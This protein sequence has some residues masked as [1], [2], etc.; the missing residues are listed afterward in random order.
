[1][2]K[3]NEIKTY[4]GLRRGVCS[5]DVLGGGGGG[6][7]YSSSPGGAGGLGGG[8]A[9]A[10]GTTYGGAG[11][12]NGANGNGGCNG[13]WANVP[14]SN[15]G[16]NTGGGGGG[17]SHYNA[18]NYGGS[19]GS[20]IVI[21]KYAGEP[22]A[23]GGTIT[24]SGGYTY[25]TFLSSGNFTWLTNS[26]TDSPV[27]NNGSSYSNDNNGSVVFNGTNQYATFGSNVNSTLTGTAWTI[28][29][30]LKPASTQNTYADI[31]GSHGGSCNC[32]I[33]LQQ[34]GSTVNQYTLGF[35][36]Q[37]SWTSTG[38]FSL[39]ADQWQ[40]LTVTKNATGAVV[41]VNNVEVARVNTTQNLT[42][43]SDLNFMIAQGFDIS[44]GRY[45]K[46]S[47][48]DFKIYNRTFT[49]NELSADYNATINKSVSNVLY[50]NVYV[51]GVLNGTT[52]SRNY[53]VNN[54]NG[55]T[56]YNVTVEPVTVYGT[57]S[58][59]T[60]TGAT[61]PNKPIIPSTLSISD[62]TPLTSVDYLVVAGGGA[63][64]GR[65]GGGG[66]AG[67]LLTGTK[68]LGAGSYG[69][70]IGNGG[71][72]VVNADAI[73][74]N[75]GN[76]T[77]LGMTAI[78]GGG[79]GSW[80]VSRNGS[81]GGSGGGGSYYGVTGSA[82]TVGQGNAGGNGNS[83]S[84]GC[85]QSGGG[86]GAGGI[87]LNAVDPVNNAN[88][89]SGAGG[90][91]IASDILGST[92]YFAGGGGGGVWGN[93]G[94][95]TNVKG[96]N[97]GIGGGGG[98]GVSSTTAGA[99]VGVGGGTA[100]NAGGNGIAS[101]TNANGGNG[102]ANTGSG[103][104]GA[105]ANPPN[106]NPS[107]AAYAATSGAGGSGIV[108]V[109]YAGTPKATGG[110]ITQVNGYTIH[111]FTSNGTFVLSPTVAS[112]TKPA[113]LDG[114]TLVQALA[115]N[116]YNLALDT[117]GIVYAWGDNTYGQTNVP[118]ELTDGTVKVAK[119]ATAVNGKNSM[120]I[121]TDG[122][123]YAWGDNTY[124]QNNVPSSFSGK[125][126]TDITV[127]TYANLAI[128]DG[129]VTQW[130]AGTANTST[131]PLTMV[132]K[133]IVKVSAGDEHFI[134][135]DS[136]GAYYFW[137]KNNY[138]G[139]TDAVPANISGKTI[140][141]IAA[142]AYH[143]VA[144]DSN[145]MVYVWGLNTQGQNTLPSDIAGKKVT[146]VYAGTSSTYAIAE[147]KLFAW[148]NGAS[149]QRAFIDNINLKNITSVSASSQL[150][151]LTNSIVATDTTV[152]LSWSKPSGG[153]VISAYKLY[154]NGTYVTTTP[155]ANLYAYTFRGLAQNTSYTVGVQATNTA[156]DG[157]ITAL[158]VQTDSAGETS[159]YAGLAD[160][161]KNGKWGL[162]T[163]FDTSYPGAP[164]YETFVNG[165]GTMLYV[166]DSTALMPQIDRANT[167]ALM[168][169][170]YAYASTDRNITWSYTSDDGTSVYVDGQQIYTGAA[171]TTISFNVKAGWH[172]IDLMY[173]DGG[174][175][176]GVWN[177]NRTVSGQFDGFYPPKVLPDLTRP[178]LWS[179]TTIAKPTYVG[180][181]SYEDI[182][183]TQS[184]Q[185]Y[186]AESSALDNIG[187]YYIGM[188]RAVVYVSSARN[189][190]LY[191]PHDDAARV[192][193]DGNSVYTYNG[194]CG[195]INQTQYL[196]AGWH[197]IDLMWEEG[198]G[199][200][201]FGLYT[202]LSSQV[203]SMYAPRIASNG[204]T[205]SYYTTPK[206]YV[207]GTVPSY[208]DLP[209]GK[210]KSTRVSDGA[211][212]V[213]NIGDN[214][215]GILRT[216]VYVPTMKTITSAMTLDKGAQI[217]V[218]GVSVFTSTTAGSKTPSITIPAGWHTLDI[219]WNEGTGSTDGVYSITAWLGSQVSQMV[220]P[221]TIDISNTSTGNTAGNVTG[222]DITSVTSNT[223]TLAWNANSGVKGYRLQWS[224]TPE[225]FNASNIDLGPSV[226]SA[227]VTGL[228]A[229]ETYYFRIAAV[230]SGIGN[231]ST[232]VAAI[233]NLETPSAPVI[234]TATSDEDSASI[235]WAPSTTTGGDAIARTNLVINPSFET[236]YAYWA[237]DTGIPTISTSTDVAKFGTKSLKLVTSTPQTNI[238]TGMSPVALGEGTY[239]YSY[240]VYSPV[241]TTAYFDAAD[242]TN[243]KVYASLGGK[244]TVPANTWTR[245]VGTFTLSGA[246]TVNIYLHN[247]YA[248]AGATTMY[249]DGVLLEA[250]AAATQY[251]DGSFTSTGGLFYTWNGTAGNSTSKLTTELT[252][253]NLA[254]NPAALTTT[255]FTTNNS[256][257]W[258][259]AFDTS[260]KRVRISN[261]SSATPI[262]GNSSS[263]GSW[264]AVGG[265]SWSN[266]GG[267]TVV[268]GKTY[269]ASAYFMADQYG[270]KGNFGVAFYDVAG[271]E[272]ANVSY[273]AEAVTATGGQPGVWTRTTKTITA[274][275]N[276]VNMR[277]GFG[278]S[279]VTGNAPQ[280]SK[281]WITDVQI[282]EGTKATPFF[283][284]WYGYDET[285]VRTNLYDNAAST[286]NVN[287]GTTINGFTGY[288]MNANSNIRAYAPLANLMGGAQYTTQWQVYNPL[289][290]EAT[291][292]ADWSDEFHTTYVIAPGETR[293]ITVTG[294]RQSYDA[295]YRF[296]DLNSIAGGVLVNNI[297][298]ELGDVP[299]PYFNGTITS[300]SD[301]TYGWVSGSTGISRAV[302]TRDNLV[303]DKGS[304]SGTYTDGIIAKNNA[305]T[306]LAQSSSIRYY[307]SLEVLLPNT[308]YTSQWE[309]YND[310][311]KP[312]SITVD[313]NDAN[314]TTYVIAPGETKII[315]LTA[316]RSSYDSTFRFVD[317][318]ADNGILVR[319]VN[320]KAGAT[321]Q[322]AVQD[323]DWDYAFT[324]TANASSSTAKGRVTYV[325]E[326]SI[327]NGVTW[328]PVDTVVSEYYN[329]YAALTT[330]NKY[331][332]RVKASAPSG[333]SAWTTINTTTWA[334]A[335]KNVETS[336]VTATSATVT[337]NAALGTQ[338]TGYK[339][340]YSTTPDF[341]SSTTINVASDV[342]TADIIGL[343]A[344]QN[345]YVRVATVNTTMTSQPSPVINFDTLVATP[346][347]PVVTGTTQTENAVTLNWTPST[348]NG[349][350]IGGN[351][352]TNPSFT[353]NTTGWSVDASG[354]IVYD[355]VNYY[356][357][358]GANKFVSTVAGQATYNTTAFNILPYET[359]TA[360]AWVK[361][362]AG[363]SFSMEIAEYTS[364][365]VYVGNTNI[366][367]TGTGDWQRIS[368]SRTMGATAGKVYFVVR[369][370]ALTGQTMYV[371]S[372]SFYKNFERT[373]LV[374]N[375]NF[376]ANT[377]GWTTNGSSLGTT[378]SQKHS[379]T[380]SAV[381]SFVYG[382]ALNRAVYSASN[383]TVAA[384]A[385]YTVSAWVKGDAG[386][387][388]QLVFR[389]NITGSTSDSWAQPVTATGEW[390]R[391]SLTF[392]TP[393]TT[394]SGI[395]IVQNTSTLA[396]IVY[397]DD[398]MLEQTAK[399][400]T[401]FDGNTVVA[402]R[403]FA[404]TGNAN[405]SSSTLNSAVVRTNLVTSP[406]GTTAFSN[407]NSTSWSTS[408]VAA[409]VPTH[410]LGITTAV[411]SNQ[412]PE[413]NT[414]KVLSL[415]NID[416]LGSSTLSRYVGVWVYVANDGYQVRNAGGFATQ[417]LTAG[418]WTFVTTPSAITGWSGVEIEKT[419]GSSPITTD[420][421]YA[422]GAIAEITPV[423]S[424]FDAQTPS[425]DTWTYTTNGAGQQIA[426]G[427]GG[428][429]YEVQYSTDGT[430]WTAAG[431]TVA[432]GI[433]IRN[434]T[435]SNNYDMRVRA[436]NTAGASA[437]ATASG[438]TLPAA[439]TGLTASEQSENSMKLSWN[440]S[441]VAVD[442]Y[443]V[444]LNDVYLATVPSSSTS[445]TYTALTYGTSY[446]LS[447]RATTPYGDGANASTTSMTTGV[448]KNGLITYLDATKTASYG[449]GTATTGNLVPNPSYEIDA[450]S[451]NLYTNATITRVADVNAAS[452]SYVGR[453]SMGTATVGLK[454]MPY[455]IYNVNSGDT[456]ST[457][458]KTRK[459]PSSQTGT[460]MNVSVAFYNSAGNYLSSNT[461]TVVTLTDAWQEVTFNG[462][463]APAGTTQAGIWFEPVNAGTTWLA[464][465]AFD[466]DSIQMTKTATA[467][468]YM[469]NTWKDLSGNANNATLYNGINLKTESVE[470]LVVAGGGGGGMDMGGGGGGGG[471]IYN[472]SYEVSVGKPITVTVGAGGNGGPAACSG[473]QPCSHQYT[474]SAT[475]GGNSSFGN[476]TAVGGGYGGSSYFGYTPNNGY[477]ATGGSGGGAS[478]YSDG[479]T[480][481]GGSG[482]SGQG[483][484][485]GG[486]S[487]QYYSGGGGGAAS[488]GISGPSQPN[489]GSGVRYSSVS[490]FYFGGGGGGAEYSAGN[491]GNGGIGG[492]G[493]GAVGVSYG[494]QGGINPGL[495]GGGGANNA[496]TNQPGGDAGANTGG[497]GGGGS[498]YNANN[499]GGQGGSGIVIVKY[500]G[501]P[502]ATGGT[503]TQT[504]GYTYHTFTSTGANT[505]AF[506]GNTTQGSTSSLA[507]DGINQ[508]GQL[509]AGY[510]NFTKGITIS[511]VVNLGDPTNYEKIVDLG[512]GASNN[513]ILVSRQGTTNNLYAEVW[514]G[515]TQLFAQVIPNVI[516]NNEDM[517]FAWTYD[518]TTST[519]NVNGKS[520]KQTSVGTI[521]NVT[522]NNAYLG[523]SNFGDAAFQDAM[524]NIEIYNRALTDAEVAQNFATF[525]KSFNFTTKASINNVPQSGLVMNLDAAN[526]DSYPGYGLV[527]KDLSGQNTN[528]E[529]KGGVGYNT[530]YGGL[531]TFDGAN[532][533]AQI[534]NTNNGLND[535][536]KGISIVGAVDFG[537]ADRYERFIDL[538]N[539]PDVNNI[540]M[541]REDVTNNL[542]VYVTGVGVIQQVDGAIKNNELTYYAWSYDGTTSTLRVNDKTYTKSFSGAIPTSTRSLSYIGKSQYAS[543]PAFE[544]SIGA[545]QIYNR[546]LTSAELTASYNTYNARY[547]FMNSSKSKVTNGLVLSYDASSTSSY[548]G[549][550]TALYDI[551]GY[552][553]SSNSLVQDGLITDLDAGNSNS[554]SGSG[555]IWYNMAPNTSATNNV[556][557][558]EVLTVAGGGAGGANLSGGGGGG[559]V[560]YNNSYDVVYGQPI[561]VTVGTGGTGVN[562]TQAGVRGGNGGN[563]VFGN[564]T[565][566]GGGGG[567]RAVQVGTGS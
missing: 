9:G 30:W 211:N 127:G 513:N 283:H 517:Y 503:I 455:P 252:R 373:N 151:V 263:I 113:S 303:A 205:W 393:A 1:M 305:W 405:A 365:L 355:A 140:V 4:G 343:T 105:A 89:I 454:A 265:T 201:G 82:G 254:I 247:I 128:V 166:A 75:G 450:S 558:V 313:W 469:D 296:A 529:L 378:T 191:G 61:L 260:V 168:L 367:F 433:Q 281:A 116:G 56:S 399:L 290:T 202:S 531:M 15:A 442:G 103:G 530:L 139:S 52:T 92:Y 317:L 212:L 302:S 119:I 480:G 196:A 495:P 444:Y 171:G 217:Y 287:A 462:L 195:P 258:T 86:G 423:T 131:P 275:A 321:A 553:Q 87:G 177:F 6:S 69:I 152:T 242:W 231:F 326:R 428:V 520:Y 181:P 299:T 70:T 310:K 459:A 377:T 473:S 155:D 266:A 101:Y 46:G 97:G 525:D 26:T 203:D 153:N 370:N 13:C 187:D 126:A 408:Y 235:V 361:A 319:N 96:G 142:G 417:P 148:G 125:K 539:G 336:N 49:A 118:A 523:K 537:K 14:G 307:M 548:P 563:S 438:K 527:W 3:V 28:S 324:G 156:G 136:N 190:T 51:N 114:K 132:G 325:V 368:A 21:V 342:L 122:A 418:T 54:L 402:G 25:H 352:L 490:P 472:N 506:T 59:S 100:L 340:Q 27:L 144:V 55:A 209:T 269:T 47:I 363:K 107:G 478:G 386:K 379:G 328:T 204:N 300:N 84:C 497:G 397:I 77:A 465:D 279:M 346:S 475:S 446:K 383:I 453:I 456:V 550:G 277:L 175:P 557:Q 206:T 11:L 348:N 441:T 403:T 410:P 512:N 535:F 364:A 158:N 245:V 60:G 85:G 374:T 375:P 218:D 292:T 443:K 174:G 486:S 170:G 99:T 173:A 356:A 237:P 362:E 244:T 391:L 178:N 556:E 106:T 432:E 41:Y 522:R 358:I 316:Q 339:V 491:G 243:T 400:N 19:G 95:W 225:M 133:T 219:M 81:T 146:A 29:T 91:G 80:D 58:Q 164:T 422:T 437:W 476:V 504:G 200:D 518:G 496:Q 331:T 157:A 10:V 359:Y 524:S 67:G 304:L 102:G 460:K 554:Y 7:A 484:A 566:I 515:G 440:A 261:S 291:V 234:K 424:Y 505:F 74:G 332:Y 215:V 354:T 371:D 565:A 145:G 123:V 272:L 546:A 199:G 16:A 457:T 430:N 482:T 271:T 64:G 392:T 31:F 163:K 413:G 426:T 315:S 162:F 214:Y 479:N 526:S 439:L 334:N 189:I 246:T 509:P 538:G 541:Y 253:T 192:Y 394:T 186:V 17:G 36:N 188:K 309:V 320:V 545:V 216:N 560:V 381:A 555:S 176:E 238:A 434:L 312:T 385:T 63:G 62:D 5:P 108:V 223:A 141:D 169:T 421:A 547:S 511:G 172:K 73:G 2:Y 42:M 382:S 256:T 366:V 230:E 532:D 323:A 38:T 130:G 483:Y 564:I 150:V 239:S 293:I 427:V 267:A 45:W 412:L 322:A 487:G 471:V 249:I 236:N 384:N 111:K 282:E 349:G 297:Q 387:P 294:F 306:R 463:T 458:V 467:T 318:A 470:V 165:N 369:N 264:Y 224:L 389:N 44:S 409:G 341:A 289:T 488:V 295:S 71:T 255:G 338:T 376:E 93:N 270:T 193:V 414:T 435:A 48:S 183:V 344:G 508:Y 180:I 78:G 498:H 562:G 329:D 57:G 198:G 76:S 416:G 233:T 68:T 124:G 210:L 109:R 536:S 117:D 129:Q 65:H 43:R 197:V 489:G 448:I 350:E 83:A 39:T 22:R 507:F 207:S 514:N 34:N 121:T 502:R 262:V 429:S 390:Q 534:Q 372:T 485:G 380:Q 110:T 20:G 425:T 345:Y 179:R 461:P 24:S 66:G 431:S 250:S 112:T 404:W 542:M 50:Y 278:V 298:I 213:Q 449:L 286:S 32:G 185:A 301:W 311:M 248:G 161:D 8:G 333:D 420:V 464:T 143:T 40:K 88:A 98:G 184:T 232:P 501:S 18:N 220:A 481:R 561:T 567:T 284:G 154:L 273:P 493:G 226:T 115:G 79:G 559:G 138:T 528:A 241:A 90:A 182:P 159:T 544:G 251:F 451:T 552:R 499:K 104:G 357:G 135:L 474:Q 360:G 516:V 500:K 388:L 337:W 447:V 551:S 327:D 411:K 347:A 353:G 494:G 23:I 147:G 445:Y 468:A 160:T 452:G 398:V 274:P 276:A 221:E 134:A 228:A 285:N 543:D 35:S 330:N 259:A 257:V 208:S 519:I 149:S 167:Y 137:G 436:V 351:M 396:N 94:A 521:N 227:T 477:G 549:S 194:C 288:K 335:P 406:R 222:L 120:A 229:G 395:V 466:I 72:A 510:A 314:N 53:T 308:N 37:G 415:Y 533:I 280:G 12:N 492:G 33:V 419:D 240:Y 540:I 268:A 401:Y 407:N